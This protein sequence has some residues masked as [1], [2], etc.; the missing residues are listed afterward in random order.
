MITVE[1]ITDKDGYCRLIMF[2]GNKRQFSTYMGLVGS[3]MDKKYDFDRNGWKF[4]EPQ[5]QILQ[6]LLDKAFPPKQ[7]KPVMSK[8]P[9]YGTTSKKIAGY[10]NIGK[11]MKLQPYQYQKETIK[12]ALDN[13]TTLLVLPC[14]SGKTPV[15]IGIY[16]EAL[17]RNIIEGCGVI[18][19]KASLKTQW[20]KEVEKFSDLT[21]T[22][23]QTSKDITSSIRAKIAR[24]ENRIKRLPSSSSSLIRELENEITA[25]S[26]EAKSKFKEQFKNADLLIMNYETLNDVKVR[27]ELHRIKPQFMFVDEIHYA[28]GAGTD[29]SK[30]LCEFADVKVRAG[31]TATPVQRDPRDIFGIFKFVNPTVFPKESDFGRL[32]L[33]WAGRG[34]VVGAK[35]EE[36]LSK[37]ISPFMIV[38]TKE[39]VSKQLPKLFVMQRYCDLE[40]AQIEMTEI[41]KSEIDELK[42][43][44]EA[45]ASSLKNP[46][47]ADKHPEIMKIQANILARQTFA[48]ELADS[49]QLL[50]RSESEMAK[51][52]IT[53]A[54]DNKMDLMVEIMEEILSSGEK[55]CLFSRFAKMQDII[56]ERIAKEAKRA[57]S[58]FKGVKIAYVN[59]KLDDKRRHQEVYEKFRDTD[60]YKI[61]LMSDA[62]AEGINLSKCKYVVEV[63]P[64]E[65]YA[66]QTQRHGRVERADS[67]HETVF[68]YQLVCND[69]WDEVSM[70]IVAKKE[71]YDCDLIKS[72]IMS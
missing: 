24:L 65:S 69:S 43:K 14:G 68:V 13:L 54:N 2:N 8:D 34:R 28:K 6:A 67:V 16:L 29:R 10:E 37:K 18:V 53:G 25:L 56:T 5:Y 71:R 47:D 51:Q 42:K 20:A 57:G 3:I 21:P 19:V 61:L 55:V 17:E 44:E 1:T 66:I 31:A 26:K 62:G 22:I 4:K 52:Y 59:G 36:M 38:K 70:K 11:S 50:I 46:A 12:F 40:P 64:A 48:Q 7:P 49:E 35:N 33:K 60:E 32:Y 27:S 9:F 72:N 41:L 39:E 30:S 45:I 23:I 63:E 15:G 58:V